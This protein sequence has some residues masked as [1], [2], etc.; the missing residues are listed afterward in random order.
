MINQISLS[1][2]VSDGPSLFLFFPFICS[3]AR[4][5][6][7]FA[8]ADP[9]SQMFTVIVLGY[10][11]PPHCSIHFS[12]QKNNQKTAKRLAAESEE[13]LTVNIGV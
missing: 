1:Q 5:A 4:S 12:V 2:L 7:Y 8:C 13:P 11:Q 6:Q 9:L 10:L 3:L